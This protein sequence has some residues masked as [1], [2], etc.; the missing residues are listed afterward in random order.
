VTAEALVV[1][2]RLGCTALFA[3]VVTT[4]A[5][6]AVPNPLAERKRE[7]RNAVVAAEAYYADHGTYAGMTLTRLRRAYDPSLRSVAIRS[8][9]RRHYC[10]GSTLRP[11]VH[12]AGPA[13]AV[14][15]GRCAG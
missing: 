8:A 6:A 12:Y 2:R 9:T 13:G 15:R 3:V 5:A 11:F 7:V 10:I 4:S 1:G 14:R